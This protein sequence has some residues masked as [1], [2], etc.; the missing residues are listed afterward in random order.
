MSEQSVSRSPQLT[1]RPQLDNYVKK[2]LDHTLSSADRQGS[3]ATLLSYIQALETLLVHAK[4]VEAAYP[5]STLTTS[6]IE[7]LDNI[8]EWNQRK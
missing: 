1:Y 4:E 7:Q 8:S 2:Q 5:G 3:P 6:T